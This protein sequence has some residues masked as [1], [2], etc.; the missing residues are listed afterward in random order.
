MPK[1]P[2][3]E[4]EALES[5]LF[6]PIDLL[7]FVLSGGLSGLFSKGA[8]VATQATQTPKML[9]GFNMLRPPPKVAHTPSKVVPSDIILGSASGG[10]IN[11]GIVDDV[12]RALISNKGMTSENLAHI[13]KSQGQLAPT[14]STAAQTRGALN[15]LQPL[16]PPT[17]VSPYSGLL[18]DILRGI[19][20]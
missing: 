3:A 14:W 17:D 19:L 6:D 2:R 12:L 13:M 9:R 10:G 5:P 15:F 7:S 20:K 4:A 1:D 16:K 8:G 18:D 11:S